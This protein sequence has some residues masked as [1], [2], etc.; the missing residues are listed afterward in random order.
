MKK[1]KERV[2]TKKTQLH[3]VR[4]GE[5]VWNQEHRMQGHQDSPLSQK[6]VLQARQLAEHLQHINVAAIY[7]SSSGRAVSTAEI[8]K[9]DRSCPLITHDAFKEIH[10][11]NGRD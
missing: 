10:L 3:L 6:G 2:M 8:L 4:H 11:G 7:S 9:R 5:T 1:E